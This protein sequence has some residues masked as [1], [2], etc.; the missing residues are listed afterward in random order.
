MR[1]TD[2]GNSPIV[3]TTSTPNNGWGSL[4]YDEGTTSYHHSPW[5]NKDATNTGKVLYWMREEFL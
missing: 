3:L 1:G 2:A 5:S 4:L